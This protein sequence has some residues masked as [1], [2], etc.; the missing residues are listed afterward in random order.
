MTELEQLREEPESWNDIMDGP[1][2]CGCE[3]PHYDDSLEETCGGYGM[4]NCYCGGD[5]CVCH[6]HGGIECDGCE[7]C[8][9]NDGNG[10]WADDY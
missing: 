10:D 6:W 2:W 5:Q 4:L 3:N 7:D 1:C 9:E 8:E